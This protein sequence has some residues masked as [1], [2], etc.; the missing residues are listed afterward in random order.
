[1]TI[2]SQ[3]PCKWLALAQIRAPRFATEVVESAGKIETKMGC[4]LGHVNAA[5]SAPEFSRKTCF[6]KQ[7]LWNASEQSERRLSATCVGKN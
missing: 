1:M 2:D 6:Q 3:I 5:A 7:K 4:T